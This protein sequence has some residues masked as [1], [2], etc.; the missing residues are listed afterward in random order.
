MRF[1]SSIAA[2]L[3]VVAVAGCS[4]ATIDF[5]GVVGEGALTSETRDVETFHGLEAG[6]GI[7]VNVSIGQ[8]Q[9]VVLEAQRNILDILE[10]EVTD[11]VLVIRASDS[12]SATRQV[13]A[14]IVVAELTALDLSGGAVGSVEG[15]MA[16]AL[17]VE[18]S[19]G[20]RMSASGHVADLQLN[21]SG[22]A[23][24]DLAEVHVG[25]ADVEVSGGGRAYLTHA[26]SVHGSASG[27]ST[28]FVG[29]D[30]AVD[31]ETS[32]GAHVE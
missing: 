25:A 23:E 30:T 1:A 27:G 6:G 13:T 26:E 32:G 7:H 5:D 29:A 2:L 10:T 11:G 21:A 12:Y 3:L 31:V 17:A 16:D 19:G 24:A 18:V 22:G 28:V 14:T 8:E 9:S 4:A 15:V 20:A